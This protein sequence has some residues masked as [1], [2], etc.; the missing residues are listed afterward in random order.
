[1][2][3]QQIPTRFTF[4]NIVYEVSYTIS[5]NIADV[6]TRPVEIPGSGLPY[7]FDISKKTFEFRELV[8]VSHSTT[9]VNALT[10]FLNTNIHL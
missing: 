4:G 7:T 3:Q 6:V 9:F 10:E 5:G 1:M 8:Q 2:T